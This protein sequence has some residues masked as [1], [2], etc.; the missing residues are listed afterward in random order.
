MRIK[1]VAPDEF[2]I[3]TKKPLNL[4]DDFKLNE[5]NT[6]EAAAKQKEQETK[7]SVLSILQ[8]E[9]KIPNSDAESVLKKRFT[10]QN[11]TTKST[12]DSINTGS[13]LLN[14]LK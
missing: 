4:P 13:S 12:L 8:T 9:E 2:K 10:E 11:T 14:N 6:A 7:D 1:D 3:I 5:P